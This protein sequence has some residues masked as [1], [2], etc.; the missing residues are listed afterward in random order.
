MGPKI[1]STNVRSRYDGLHEHGRNKNK[2][3]KTKSNMFDYD[4]RSK[5]SYN[6][7]QAKTNGAAPRHLLQTEAAMIVEK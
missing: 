5:L 3:S 4:K 1:I 7:K 6:K 2:Q